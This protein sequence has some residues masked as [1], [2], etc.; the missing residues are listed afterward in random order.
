MKKIRVG[1]FGFGKT[2]KVI[3]N[4]F[5]NDSQFA[6]TWVVRKGYAD[7]H[8]Y[9]SRLLGY[10][11]DAGKIFSIE[12]VDNDFFRER[13]VDALVDFSD[14]SGVYLYKK[15][16]EAG[17]SIVSAISKYE[18]E[19]ID[20]IKSLAKYNRVLYSPNIT[21]GINVLMVAAQILQKIAPHADIEIVEEHFKGKREVSGTAKRI[22]N[23]LG[24][25]EE[26]H[27]NSIR[28]G[29]IVGR[30]EII[31]GMPNQTIRLQH[32]SINRAAFGQGAI[33]A[34]KCLIGQPPGLYTMETIIA[35]MFRQ[36]IPVY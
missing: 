33:F 13:P 10:E 36:N 1:I 22:A 17:I 7:H 32:E 5:L 20:L 11:F 24:L 26:E 19:E 31:F 25:N 34:V 35:E 21:L 12:D 2:G 4:E 14:S 29:G 9:A 8:K 6:L 27:L 23:L 16:A 30:H 15:A 3:A 18:Q 28:V